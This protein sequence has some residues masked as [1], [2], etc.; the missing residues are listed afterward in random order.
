MIASLRLH[1]ISPDNRVLLSEECV[2]VGILARGP[3]DT[4]E[5][6]L[7]WFDWS[8]ARDLSADGSR[9]LINES[10]EGGGAD[11]AVYLRRTDGSPAVLC[12]MDP[13][14]RSRRTASGCL[15]HGPVWVS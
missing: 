11:Y 7:S 2:R 6:D 10:G 1:D 14:C 15:P 13:A 9:L 8:I 12:R 3:R 4:A 5:R